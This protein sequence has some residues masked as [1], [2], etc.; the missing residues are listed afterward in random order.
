MA[1]PVE[2]KYLKQMYLLSAEV[3][4]IIDDYKVI[5]ALIYYNAYFSSLLGSVP[6]RE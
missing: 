4:I 2:K 3:G 5:M 1:R 6:T